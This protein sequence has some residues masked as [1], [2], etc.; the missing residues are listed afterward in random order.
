MSHPFRR[1][2][3]TARTQRPQPGN[4]PRHLFGIALIRLTELLAQ[5]VLFKPYRDQDVPSGGTGEKQP[6]NAHIRNCPESDDEADHNRVAHQAI[7]HRLAEARLAISRAGYGLLQPEQV[8][9]SNEE[10]AQDE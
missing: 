4:E 5:V 6:A 1:S 8:K 3:R 7:E 10:C 2:A 9:V